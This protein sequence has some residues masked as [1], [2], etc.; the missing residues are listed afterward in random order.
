MLTTRHACVA[1]TGTTPPAGWFY[2]RV[3]KIEDMPRSTTLKQDQRV[4]A[5]ISR[6]FGGAMAP[7]AVSDRAQ[8]NPF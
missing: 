6:G 4:T 1:P 8:D 5:T 3:W 2:K 7:T